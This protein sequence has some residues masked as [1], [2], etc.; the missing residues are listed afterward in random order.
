MA[1]SEKIFSTLSNFLIGIVLNLDISDYPKGYRVYSRRSVRSIIKNYGKIEDSF[2]ILSEILLILKNQNFKI[3]EIVSI[4]INR[5]RGE[6][7]VNN[8]LIIDSLVGLLKLILVKLQNI[9]F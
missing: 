9:K 8:G 1:F 5:K 2:N 3:G 4:F 7:I 6:S